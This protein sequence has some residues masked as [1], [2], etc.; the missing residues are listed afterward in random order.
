M[1]AEVIICAV[2]LLSGNLF[3]SNLMISLAHSCSGLINRF[4]DIFHSLSDGSFCPTESRIWFPEMNC[5][6]VFEAQNQKMA[7]FKVFEERKPHFSLAIDLY[8]HAVL[9]EHQHCM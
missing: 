2:C 8:S 1:L 3:K 7:S 4:I 6:L 5:M 9:G